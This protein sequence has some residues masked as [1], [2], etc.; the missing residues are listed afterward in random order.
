MN[1]IEADDRDVIRSHI[2]AA[3]TRTSAEFV[4]VI[5]QSADGYLFIPTLAAAVATLFLSGVVLLFRDAFPITA[6]ELYAGQVT[7][8]AILALVCRVPEIRYSLVPKNIRHTRASRLAHQMFIDLNLSETEDRNAV[9]LFVALGERYVE[10]IADKGLQQKHGNSGAWDRIVASFV[11]DVREGDVA[12]GF[13]RA[14]DGCADV[15]AEHFPN[16][17]GAPNR[18]PDRLIEI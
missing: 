17:E 6:T 5:A 11:Q 8:F 1:R 2:E 10:V 9:L 14:I 4:T 3:E 12:D 13:A 7:L 18:F 16:R 15:M